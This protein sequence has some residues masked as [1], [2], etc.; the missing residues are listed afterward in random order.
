MLY[1]RE[2]IDLMA[3]HPGRPFKVIELRRYVEA[4]IGA[5]DKQRKDAVRRGVYRV[6]ETLIDTGVVRRDKFGYYVW[7][8]TGTRS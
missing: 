2:T 4:T 3:A 8:K 5:R 1:A 7:R 6:I